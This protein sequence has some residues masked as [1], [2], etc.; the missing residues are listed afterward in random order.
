MTRYTPPSERTPEQ[1]AAILSAEQEV[2]K[3]AGASARP[4]I[5]NSPEDVQMVIAYIA[6]GAAEPLAAFVRN[7]RLARGLADQRRIDAHGG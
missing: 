3:A 5:S 6:T 4:S 1:A 7:W 2:A